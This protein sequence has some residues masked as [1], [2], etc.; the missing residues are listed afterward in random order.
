MQR[1]VT[2]RHLLATVL[3]A[4]VLGAMLGA[5]G[6]DSVPAS[7]PPTSGVTTQDTTPTP[8]RPTGADDVLVRV[9]QGVNGFT[10]AASSFARTPAV[11]IA[12]D[13]KVITPGAMTMQYPGP[14]VAPL[15][16]R[17]LDDEGVETVLALAADKGLLDVPPPDYEEGA[18]QVTDVGSTVVVLDATGTPVVHEA[19]AL[20][21]EDGGSPA[22][23]ALQE[24]VTAVTDL[25]SLVGAEHLGAETQYVPTEYAVQAMPVNPA[26]FSSDVKPTIVPWPSSTGVTLASTVEQ[27][28][29]VP[30]ADLAGV[31]EGATELTFFRE[32]AATYQLLV[33]PQTPGSPTCG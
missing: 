27:C 30:G 31:L 12:G 3:V 19:Y 4:P 17:Q 23:T 25:S 9:D 6:D 22:R 18:P 10:T 7:S 11:V 33:R 15:S 21:M 5:C 2:R 32:G 28:V 8:S 1:L 24:F 29:T 14:L 13:G 16:V 26:D 20:G